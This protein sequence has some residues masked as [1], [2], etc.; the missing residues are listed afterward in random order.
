MK[1]VVKEFEVY[2][3]KELDKDIQGKL[4]DEEK[5]GCLNLYCDIFLYEDMTEKAKELLQKY[6]GDNAEFNGVC[7]DLGY[8]QGD[9]A[10]IEFDLNY[11][12]QSICVCNNGKYCHQYSFILNYYGDLGEKREQKLKEKI[13]NMNNELTDF[14]YDLIDIDNFTDEALENLESRTYLKNGTIFD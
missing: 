3:Y 10:M 11:Y 6:F 9:G 5:E 14:D 13:V 7:Y 4:L 8:S 2:N 1:K 12:N